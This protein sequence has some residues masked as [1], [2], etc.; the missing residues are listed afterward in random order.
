MG[1]LQWVKEN[2]DYYKGDVPAK[3][4]G[5]QDG[6]VGGQMVQKMIAMVE[7]QLKQK[8]KNKRAFGL[9]C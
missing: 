2:N 1:H 9:F 3:V 8:I 5:K 6:P 7:N 4:N